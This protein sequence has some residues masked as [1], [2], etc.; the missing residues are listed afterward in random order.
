MGAPKPRCWRCWIGRLR[1]LMLNPKPVRGGEVSVACG[2]CRACCHQ[3]VLLEPSE[4]GYD[5]GVIPT[6][7]G[8]ARF[9]RRR[10]DGAWLF[11]GGGDG[12]GSAGGAAWC[13][14]GR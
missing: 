7:E 3:A 8:A 4:T 13:R 9:L 5:E 2:G 10:G 12:S 14:G 1:A 6:L 11:L